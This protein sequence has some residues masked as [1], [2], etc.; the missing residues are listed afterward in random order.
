MSAQTAEGNE[1]GLPPVPEGWERINE[2]R[3]L[4]KRQDGEKKR[5]QW[6][7]VC[8]PRTEFTFN[9]KGAKA[10]GYV[11]IDD[12]IRS[13]R[14]EQFGLGKALEGDR[15]LEEFEEGDDA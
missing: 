9:T 13:H 5:L 3:P 14:P 1:D 11:R 15:G 10:D 2:G 4:L 8:G 12:H 7:P 6:C